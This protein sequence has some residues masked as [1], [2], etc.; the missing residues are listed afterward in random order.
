MLKIEQ[1]VNPEVF[2]R[3]QAFH[4][5]AKILHENHKKKLK[6]YGDP[7]IV[8]SALS[9]EL[10]LKSM[11]SCL[12]FDDRKN[13]THEKVF[14]YEK[15]FSKAEHGHSL[16]G[17]FKKIPSEFQTEIKTRCYNVSKPIKI[18]EFFEKH[19]ESFVNHRY[20]FEGKT[21]SYEA[22]EFLIVMDVLNNFCNSILEQKQN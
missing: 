9:I 21:R 17:L 2:Y 18:S 14:I 6:Y 3:A 1:K 13:T 4:I 8:N 7:F 11:L 15:V 12:Y 20:S 5:A 16:K 22:N 10:Y 19:A